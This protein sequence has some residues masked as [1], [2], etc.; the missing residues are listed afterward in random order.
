MSKRT[1]V[2][3]TSNLPDGKPDPALSREVELFLYEDAELLDSW[4]L[5][6]W[7][8]RFTPDGQYLIPAT[9]RPTGDPDVDLFFVRDDWFLLG[10]RVD[11][12]LNGTAWAES[13]QSTTRHLVSNV[14]AW[15]M[16][17]GTIEVAA[18][19]VVYRSILDRLDTYPGYYRMTLLRG[20]ASGFEIRT[21]RSTLSMAQLR[22]HGR[23]SVLL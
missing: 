3:P 10:Q 9:D 5:R 19:F 2:S 23:V 17:D 16:D 7:Y 8:A 18:N 11:A 12:M 15:T 22:P 4:Q 13:P 1:A 6:E 14:R 21:R 20:G